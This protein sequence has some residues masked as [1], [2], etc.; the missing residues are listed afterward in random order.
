MRHGQTEWNRVRRLQ[1]HSDID[2]N[3]NGVSLA[4]EIGEKLRDVKIDRV[5]T[6]PLKRAK[7]TAGYVIG[8]RKIPII[9]EDRIE[10]IS[11][12]I[13][14]G[15]C[16]KPDNCEVPIDVFKDFN[17]EPSK[18][19]PPEGG[20]SIKDMCERTRSFLDELIHTSKYQD[21]TIL[22]STHGAATRAL[23]YNLLPH[24]LDDFWLGK[25]PPNC[26]LNIFEIENGKVM[27]F[28]KD[29]TSDQL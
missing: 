15:R 11:F 2:L 29:V 17:D 21:E 5:F 24:E 22:I 7:D 4:K 25:V 20:E 16:F 27:S 12:G 3:E 19:V 9:I 10:E 28:E 18:Y 1:G 8:D 14:E 13:W 6:S 26:S 23:M